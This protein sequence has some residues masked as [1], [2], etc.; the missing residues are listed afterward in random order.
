MSATVAASR[1]EKLL[2]KQIHRSIG[3]APIRL[4]FSG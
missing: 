3:Q 1:F 2:L 4:G